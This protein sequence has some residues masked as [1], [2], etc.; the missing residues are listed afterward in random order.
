MA[1]LGTLVDRQTVSRAGDAGTTTHRVALTT[2]AHSLPATNPET[3]FVHLRSI[4]ALAGVPAVGVRPFL[5]GGN[6][7]ILTLGYEY[8]PGA[9]GVS[10]ATL[11]FDIVAL[12]YHSIIR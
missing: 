12:V 5:L 3:A 1:I 4:E 2:L 11:M 10:A 7:S 6:A 9:T 8:A